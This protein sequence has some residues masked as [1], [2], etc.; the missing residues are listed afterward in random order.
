MNAQQMF[1]ESIPSI[2]YAFIPQI[3]PFFPPKILCHLS[4]ELFLELQ[5]F[6]EY[7][8]IYRTLSFPWGLAGKESSYNAGDLGLI[9]GFGRSPGEGKGWLS[10]TELWNS[11]L[12]LDIYP[13]GDVGQSLGWED[14]WRRKWQST[15]VFLPGKS[16]RQ[17]SLGGNSPWG[18]KSWTWLKRHS[19]H[20]HLTDYHLSIYASMSIMYVKCL[21]GNWFVVSIVEY[22]HNGKY[23]MNCSHF[24]LE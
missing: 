24:R 1:V 13:L 20:V 18:H 3:I 5:L 15:L 4:S 2:I 14:P 23:C 9:P 6:F 17:R 22:C 8:T 12:P 16:Y 7:V 11:L 19:S 10:F 21:S